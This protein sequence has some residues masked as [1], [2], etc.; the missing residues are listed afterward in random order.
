MIGL[1]QEN[2]MWRG[3][4]GKLETKNR[5]FKLT[6]SQDIRVYGSV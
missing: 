1:A 4:E 3:Y 5:I 2:E 6:R